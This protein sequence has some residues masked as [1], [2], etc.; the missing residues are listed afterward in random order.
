VSRV[1]PARGCKSCAENA[2]L[3]GRYGKVRDALAAAP[4]NMFTERVSTFC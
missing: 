2:F 1:H 4:K 3:S